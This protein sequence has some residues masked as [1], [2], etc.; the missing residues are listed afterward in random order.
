MT[1]DFETRVQEIE[2]SMSEDGLNTVTCGSYEDIYTDGIDAIKTSGS[3]RRGGEVRLPNERL[4]VL[5]RKMFR[6]QFTDGGWRTQENK[7]MEHPFEY[8]NAKIIIDSSLSAPEFKSYQTHEK[9]KPPL[10]HF[11]VV[12]NMFDEMVY[13]VRLLTG[14]DSYGKDDLKDDL[15][16]FE[17]MSFNVADI[18]NCSRCNPNI[19]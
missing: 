1:E 3:S 13:I 6:V 14:D 12:P 4:A 15:Q 5:W 17:Q 10:D 2:E 7:Q 11:S 18:E 9:M 8:S 16:C 19:Y